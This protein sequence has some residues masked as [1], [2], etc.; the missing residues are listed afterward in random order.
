[1]ASIQDNIGIII[2]PSQEDGE[3]IA[4][5]EPMDYDDSDEI[6]E[7]DRGSDSDYGRPHKSKGK[8][9]RGRPKTKS[10]EEARVAAALE[11]RR[12][13][14]RLNHS[15]PDST[16]K[17]PRRHLFGLPAEWREPSETASP[18]PSKPANAKNDKKK[19]NRA[20]SPYSPTAG[21]MTRRKLDVHNESKLSEQSARTSPSLHEGVSP[22]SRNSLI[23]KLK[24][25]TPSATME[26][27]RH[28]KHKSPRGHATTQNETGSKVEASGQEGHYVRTHEQKRATRSTTRMTRQWQGDEAA[29]ETHNDD[30]ESP[31][32]KK[33]SVASSRRRVTTSPVELPETPP[34]AL[35]SAY[36]NDGNDDNDDDISPNPP[37]TPINPPP[38]SPNTNIPSSN[39]S[40]SPRI[41]SS[42]PTF[43]L[44]PPMSPR[45]LSPFTRGAQIALENLLAD[46]HSNPLASLIDLVDALDDTR[47]IVNDWEHVTVM[48]GGRWIYQVM[49]DVWEEAEGNGVGDEDVDEDGDVDFEDVLGKVGEWV[50]R[51]MERL[52]GSGGG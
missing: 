3:A 43:A 42:T 23:V 16:E 37:K 7:D 41:T 4:S 35:T 10:T 26:M 11:A 5:P 1:M 14:K 27:E 52:S 51:E 12:R 17:N 25:R 24:T 36:D 32:P 21:R 29:T 31:Q 2:K 45:S 33:I 6:A 9:M 46:H 8:R 34:D 18:T 47:P 22:A 30:P 50:G 38:S 20:T 39:P 13:R 19:A 40:P 44:Y 49:R 28:G 48:K 15:T